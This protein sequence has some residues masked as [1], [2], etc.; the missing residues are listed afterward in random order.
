[1]YIGLGNIVVILLIVAVFAALR[2]RS[3]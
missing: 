2:R 3:A 1:M